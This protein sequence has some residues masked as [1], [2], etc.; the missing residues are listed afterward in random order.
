M[1]HNPYA[2]RLSA[3]YIEGIHKDAHE[4]LCGYLNEDIEKILLKDGSREMSSYLDSSRLEGRMDDHL[5]H[6]DGREESISVNLCM[7]LAG[8]SDEDSFRHELT[9]LIHHEYLHHVFKI[10]HGMTLYDKLM[11]S[12]DDNPF[13]KNEADGQKEDCKDL[14]RIALMSTN[15]A[16][17]YAVSDEINERCTY[18]HEKGKGYSRIIGDRRVE[19]YISNMYNSFTLDLRGEK[20]VIP[21]LAEF[22][23]KLRNLAEKPTIEM[24]R[25][26]GLD[27]DAKLYQKSIREYVPVD[28]EDEK[29]A[30]DI[31]SM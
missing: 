27:V 1:L 24:R 6:Y 5:G 15:E 16:F 8:T 13:W 14:F 23:M 18:D 21:N 9:S 19:N 28:L 20:E 10:S 26:E 29:S 12:M 11:L 7:L 4:R 2:M 31:F 22:V 3:P 17:S 30:M 25:A